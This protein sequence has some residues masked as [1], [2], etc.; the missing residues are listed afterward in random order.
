VQEID[1]RLLSS[2]MYFRKPNF[3]HWIWSLIGCLR[4]S[5]TSSYGKHLQSGAFKILFQ[6]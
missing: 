3:I 1:S 4:I 2:H 6:I 5:V